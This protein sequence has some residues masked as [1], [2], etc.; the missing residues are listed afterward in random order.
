M[1]CFGVDVGSTEDLSDDVRLAEVSLAA[2][3]LKT[4][5]PGRRHKNRRSKYLIVLGSQTDG[6]NRGID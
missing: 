6:Y 2:S 5:T 3:L 4:T 1:A